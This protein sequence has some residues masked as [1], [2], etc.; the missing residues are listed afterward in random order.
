MLAVSIY[1]I[2]RDD[3][4]SPYAV[5]IEERVERYKMHGDNLRAVFKK[6]LPA[7]D[8]EAIMKRADDIA[9][10]DDEIPN[11]FPLG[12]DS[13]GTRPEIWTNWEDFVQKARDS[14]QSARDLKKIAATD[15]H[16]ATA[17]ASKKLGATCKACHDLYRITH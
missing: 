2:G 13:K 5:L 3:D 16:A 8:F 12:S 1:Q 7:G 15:A 4:V 10:W 11:Y 6:H 14:A 17:T 9:A